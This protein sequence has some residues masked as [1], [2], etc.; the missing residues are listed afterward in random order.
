MSFA[1]LVI[2]FSC[3]CLLISLD[4]SGQSTIENSETSQMSFDDQ[5][6]F[7]DVAGMLRCPTCTGLSV[8]DSDAKFSVQIQN[9]VKKQIDQGKSKE[10]IL[11]YFEKR[12]GPWILRQPPKRGFHIVAWVFPLVLI[13]LGPL[14]VWFMVWRRSRKSSEYMVRSADEIAEEFKQ[15]I[16][17]ALAASKGS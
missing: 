16:N 2:Y 3:C 11:N 15:A 8:L 17:Q 6:V 14:I 12:Y 1:R 9:L 5:R 7:K 10:D 13:V 4:V